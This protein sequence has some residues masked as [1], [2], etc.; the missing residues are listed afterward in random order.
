LESCAATG[1]QDDLIYISPRSGHA[2]SR[3]A[4][5][6]YADRMLPLPQFLIGC[7]AATLTEVRRALDLTGWFLDNRVRPAFDMAEL[8][9]ARIRLLRLLDE[10]KADAPGQGG[11]PDGSEL[12]VTVKRA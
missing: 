7:G 2:V 12:A 5:A 6:P 9:A 8:P 11:W 3:G 1:V 4:G 10:M